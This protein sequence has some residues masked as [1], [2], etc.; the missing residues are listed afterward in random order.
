ML[1][2]TQVEL[3]LL[4][5]ARGL[6]PEDRG[7]PAS[8]LPHRR[9]KDMQPA[10][11]T[12][13][14]SKRNNRR[15]GARQCSDL[16]TAG[17]SDRATDAIP[18]RVPARL[19]DVYHVELRQFPHNFCRFNMTEEELRTAVLDAWSREQRFDLDGRRWDPRQASLT[20]LE[21]PSLEGHEL[22]MG[23]GWRNAQRRSEDVTE[24]LMTAR[25]EPPPPGLSATAT[26]EAPEELER[27]ALA[28]ALVELL[29]EDPVALMR[30]WQLAL[31]RHPDRT[32]SACL[33]LAE[34]LVRR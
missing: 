30:A 18:A 10:N 33:E 26:R 29:G 5:A 21:G 12:R 7:C 23:R 27:R 8:P 22:S 2:R 11:L 19:L 14:D 3:C 25:R 28:S 4:L 13:G 32:A 16:A 31:E 9:S 24:Q 1:E 20:V 34:E 15:A 6:P 17:V